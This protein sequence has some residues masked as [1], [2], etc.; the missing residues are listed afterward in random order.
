MLNTLRKVL[1][2]GVVALLISS[3]RAAAQTNHHPLK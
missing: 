3:G 2:T 1:L